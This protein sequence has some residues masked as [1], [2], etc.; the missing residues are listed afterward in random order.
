MGHT[1][2]P[3]RDSVASAHWIIY[4]WANACRVWLT[5]AL[6]AY[7]LFASKQKNRGREKNQLQ[8]HV[9]KMQQNLPRLQVAAV[10]ALNLNRVVQRA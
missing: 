10:A 8:V 7:L 5:L 3:V 6:R 4:G 2:V 9:L 1:V